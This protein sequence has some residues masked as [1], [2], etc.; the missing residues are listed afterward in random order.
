MNT[1]QLY[2]KSASDWLNAVGEKVQNASSEFINTESKICQDFVS[3][4]ENLRLVY[5]N[6][7]CI[8]TAKRGLHVAQYSVGISFI[9][10]NNESE[11]EKYLLLAAESK[12]IPAYLS[13]GRIYSNKSFEKSLEWY[14][15]YFFQSTDEH[16]RGIAASSIAKLYKKNGD[17]KNHKHWLKIC[18]ETSYKNK[19][20]N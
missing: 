9:L 10:N 5:K 17:I 15:K 13:L 16:D 1:S 14:I 8:N 18:F 7:A 20:E 2:K 4:S 3:N 11:A 6:T 19:C 12:H